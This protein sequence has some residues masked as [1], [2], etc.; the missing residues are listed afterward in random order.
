MGNYLTTTQCMIMPSFQADFLAFAQMKGQPSSGS[1]VRLEQLEA[2]SA[3]NE[4]FLTEAF[5]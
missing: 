4:Q 5:R 1:Q 2:N 3:L